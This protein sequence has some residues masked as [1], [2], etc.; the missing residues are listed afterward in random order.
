MPPLTGD[1]DLEEEFA[2]PSGEVGCLIARKALTMLA[3][4]NEG[5]Q[6]ENIFYTHC[7]VKDRVCSLI[8]DGEVAPLL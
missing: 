8:I 5:S 7:N 6:R 2:L 3:K 4:E 1:R